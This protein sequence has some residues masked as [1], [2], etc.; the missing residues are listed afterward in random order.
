MRLR[1]PTSLAVGAAA[2]VA[3]AGLSAPT[4]ASASPEVADVSPYLSK[5]LTGLSGTTLVLVH[6]ESLQAAE[7]GGRGHRHDDVD[8]LPQDRRRRRARHQGAD[9]RR[10][11]ASRA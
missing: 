4:S 8:D 10:C 3:A 2:V 1:I 6:G 7:V 5:Q 11:A 9:R